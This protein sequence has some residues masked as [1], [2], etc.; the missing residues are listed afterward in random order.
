MPNVS[1]AAIPNDKEIFWCV[2][3]AWSEPIHTLLCIITRANQFPDDNSF[4]QKLS[5]IGF[6]EGWLR[7]SRG[8]RCM[9]VRSI[10][11]KLIEILH[12]TF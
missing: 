11:V 5:P 1:A 9:D 12:G 10:K 7:S 2:G 4:C 6:E 8:K 3:Q